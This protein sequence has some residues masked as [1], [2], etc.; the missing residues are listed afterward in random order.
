MTGSVSMDA[1]GAEISTAAACMLLRFDFLL[2]LSFFL[3]EDAERGNFS[4]SGF[5]EETS[6]SSL[7][8][9]SRLGVSCSCKGAEEFRGASMRKGG[10]MEGPSFTS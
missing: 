1:S 2:F 10:S 6:S 5:G 3:D 4:S 8:T 7:S 9:I